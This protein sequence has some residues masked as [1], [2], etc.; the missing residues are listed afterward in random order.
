[1]IRITSMRVFLS[2]KKSVNVAACFLG[3]DLMVKYGCILLKDCPKYAMWTTNYKFIVYFEQIYIN[4]HSRLAV[5]PSNL[6]LE[7]IM[8]QCCTNALLSWKEDPHWGNQNH[9]VLCFLQVLSCH[10]TFASS[11][12]F[13]LPKW[14][15]YRKIVPWK[16]DG[17]RRFFTLILYYSSIFLL[18]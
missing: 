10:W 9:K 13:N 5:T 18:C 11:L 14:H 2:E 6:T 16:G 8:L 17:T 4:V 7:N 12:F 3:S 15:L 1:M